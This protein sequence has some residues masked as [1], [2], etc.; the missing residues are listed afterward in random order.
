MKQA[1]ILVGLGVY[2][3]VQ[4]FV[5]PDLHPLELFLSASALVIGM[6]SLGWIR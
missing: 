6:G 2:G 5:A 4:A 1:I 3:I